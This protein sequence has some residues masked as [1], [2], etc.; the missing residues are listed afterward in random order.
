MKQFVVT[1]VCLSDG[2]QHR[3]CPPF[4]VEDCDTPLIHGGEKNGLW[5]SCWCVYIYDLADGSSW[6][7]AVLDPGRTSFKR[8]CIWSH[9]CSMDVEEKPSQSCCRALSRW[10]WT[11]GCPTN[12]MQ[13]QNMANV[14][15]HCTQCSV[16]TTSKISKMT[17]AVLWL[18][19]M[20]RH[21]DIL[22][23]WVPIPFTTLRWSLEWPTKTS[24]FATNDVFN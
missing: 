4:S 1:Q 20:P 23:L 18:R 11:I 24:G 2:C 21:S 19:L 3:V 6:S 13:P 10:N 16:T 9:R 12:W 14:V 5:C 7:F 22:K 8:I 15:L 17:G